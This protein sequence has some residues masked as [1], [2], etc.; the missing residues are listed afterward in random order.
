MH[1]TRMPIVFAFGALLLATSRSGLAQVVQVPTLGTFSIQT[2]VSVPD[3]GASY[4]G[5][6]RTGSLARPSRGPMGSTALGSQMSASSATVRATVIDLDEFDRMIRSQASK[7]PTLPEL[8]AES[9]TPSKFPGSIKPKPTQN[10]HYAYLAA[11][12]HAPDA[13]HEQANEDARYYLSLAN[14]ARQKGHWHAVELYYKLAWESLPQ[15][16]REN[17]ITALAQA[18]ENPESKTASKSQGATR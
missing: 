18:R 13:L 15:S 12:S 14:G 16:R 1:I 9:A 3:S 6:N 2:N 17:A 8:N 7:K 5:G 4:A 11:L 10:P